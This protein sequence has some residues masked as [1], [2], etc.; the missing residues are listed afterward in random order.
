MKEIS[1]EITIFGKVG[2]NK[3]QDVYIQ[4]VFELYCGYK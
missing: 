2:V 1:D 3:G 4:K